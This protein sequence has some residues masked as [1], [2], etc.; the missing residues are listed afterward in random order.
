MLF[1]G[2]AALRYLGYYVALYAPG[3]FPTSVPMLRRKTD[4][5][6]KTR[7]MTCAAFALR[8]YRL[9]FRYKAQLFR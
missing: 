2:F 8:S 9:L 4:P 5:A 7:P 6:T 1:L 3:R